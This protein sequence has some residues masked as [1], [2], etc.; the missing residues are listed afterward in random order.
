[1]VTSIYGLVNASWLRVT[2][3]TVKLA[4]L[5]ADWRGGTLALVADLHL[6]NG[7]G[8]RFTRRVVAKLQQL[9]A[10]AVLNSGDLFDGSKA[11]LEAILKPWKGLSAPVGSLFCHRQ[12]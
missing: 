11:A 9:Q 6:G 3:L 5:P 1:M 12:S 8:T 10:D 4:N 7:R 2:R